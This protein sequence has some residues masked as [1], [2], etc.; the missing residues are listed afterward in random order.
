MSDE[1]DKRSPM[2][3]SRL[4]IATHNVRQ[5][6]ERIK[7]VEDDPQM[8]GADKLSEIKKIK[9]EIGKLNG[10]IDTIKKE[11]TLMKMYSVN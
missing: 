7:E 2:I 3:A 10:E 11:I 5:L 4:L 8:T 1:I 6:I 9:A